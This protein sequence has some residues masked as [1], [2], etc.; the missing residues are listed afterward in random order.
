MV[1]PVTEPIA[2]SKLH[3]TGNDFLVHVALSE[4]SR[5]LAPG[6]VAGLCDRHRGV[7]ADGLIR[8]ESGT[9]GADCRMVLHNADG[10][11]AEMTGNG[12]RCL[13]WVAHRNRLGDGKR[14]I[15]DTDGGRREIDLELDPATD[16][17]VYATVD[18]GPVTFDPLE[19]PLDAPS[20]FDLEATFHGTT[21]RGDAAGIGNP[22]L[23][24]FVDDP[25]TARVAQH[26]PR[27]EHDARFPRRTNVEFIALG[28]GDADLTMRVWERGVGETLS[29]GTGACAAAA[30][31]HHRG[32]VG[33]EVTV[34]VLG[35]DLTVDLG[36]TVRL[37]G[38]VEHVFDVVVDGER[39]NA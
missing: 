28:P 5:A 17:V 9:D 23:V 25:A 3:A 35:G 16:A 21:Y 22:H 14:L 32:L 2:L 6:V 36:V 18:M 13:A 38:P 19:I 7:G 8:I 12:S 26:G 20:P 1:V 34:H 29:C 33:D 39:W 11:R 37:G 4:P 24:L 30:V 31:A 27:L 10:S 15:V